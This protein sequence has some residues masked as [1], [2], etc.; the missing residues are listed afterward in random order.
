[1]LCL[2]PVFVIGMGMVEKLF[3]R[4]IYSVYLKQLFYNPPKHTIILEI[5]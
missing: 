3:E 2:L 5:L 1:M 4:E